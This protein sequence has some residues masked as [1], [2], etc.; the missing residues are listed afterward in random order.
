MLWSTSGDAI[1]D[2]VKEVSTDDE[3]GEGNCLLV[4]F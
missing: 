4:W 1:D 2:C 3:K